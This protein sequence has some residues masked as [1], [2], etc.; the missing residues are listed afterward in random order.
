MIKKKSD[1]PCPICERFISRHT[2]KE[3]KECSDILIKKADDALDASEKLYE[4]VKKL[5][6]EDK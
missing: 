4:L 2:P 3:I 6:G 5:K 1:I